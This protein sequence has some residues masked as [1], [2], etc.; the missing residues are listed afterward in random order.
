MYEANPKV[1]SVR[2]TGSELLKRAEVAA[3]NGELPLLSLIHLIRF[4]ERQ[5][6]VAPIV[7]TVFPDL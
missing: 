5:V 1:N 4:R 3:E 2:N 6:E 7:R